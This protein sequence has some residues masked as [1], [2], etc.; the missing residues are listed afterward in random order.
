LGRT[1]DDLDYRARP[2][3]A[4]P[5]TGKQVLETVGLAIVVLGIIVMLVPMI[6]ATMGRNPLAQGRAELSGL[7]DQ[8]LRDLR[9]RVQSADVGPAKD[10]PLLEATARDTLARRTGLWFCAGGVVAAFGIALSD[11]ADPLRI[12]FFVVVAVAMALFA[13]AI[14]T[15]ARGAAAFLEPN[16]SS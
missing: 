14:E 8:Q 7:S 1:A 5:V 9:R 12:G 6:R 2:L 4:V 10:R 11:P 3:L 16:P 15:R 13:R